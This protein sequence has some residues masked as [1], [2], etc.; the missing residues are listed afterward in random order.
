MEIYYTS[1]LN[2]KASAVAA[3]SKVRVQPRL[4]FTLTA[5]SRGHRWLDALG[6]A[7]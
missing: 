2:Q 5:C 3:W 4:G 7:L 1:Q 6:L